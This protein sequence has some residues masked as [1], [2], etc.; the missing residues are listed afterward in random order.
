MKTLSEFSEMIQEET[1]VVLGK[2]A[3]L[4][5]VSALDDVHRQ[6]SGLKAWL[7]WHERHSEQ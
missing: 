4:P 1:I 6:S 7:A 2:E 5:V 3:R